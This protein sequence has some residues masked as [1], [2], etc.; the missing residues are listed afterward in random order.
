MTRC[1]STNRPEIARVNTSFEFHGNATLVRYLICNMSQILD[2]AIKRAEC[3]EWS[4]TTHLRVRMHTQ[5]HAHDRAP[6]WTHNISTHA[7]SLAHKHTHTNTYARTHALRH[8]CTYTNTRTHRT[9][10]YH[11]RVPMR[12]TTQMYRPTHTQY[13]E[14]QNSH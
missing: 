11:A 7:R 14:T 2:H 5:S 12:A 6:T 10:T 8:T 4:I 3:D 13:T 1:R 9:N